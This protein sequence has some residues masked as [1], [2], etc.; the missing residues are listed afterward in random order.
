M[1]D[2]SPRRTTGEY[3]DVARRLGT[4]ASALL[5]AAVV[6]VTG[7][8]W[9]RVDSLESAVKRVS[10]PRGS[11]PDGATDILVVGTDSRVDVH[12]DAMSEAELAR[13]H[14]GVDDGGVNTD[15]IILIRIPNDGHSAT[16]MSIPR[17][18]YVEVPRIGKA[19]INAAFGTAMAGARARLQDQG[20]PQQR[21]DDEAA[22]AGRAA[23]VE[24]VANLTGVTVDHYAEVGLMGF[25]LLTSAVGGVDV[26]LAHAV[27]DDYSGARFP[28]GRQVLDGPRALS[29]VRQRHG[30]PR[31]DL[32]RIVRQQVFMASFAHKVLSAG[33]LADPGTLDRLQRAIHRSVTIDDRWDTV[34]FARQLAD[35]SAGSVRFATIPVVRDDG[36]SDDGQ[37]SVVIV[38]PAQVQAYT[39]ALLGRRPGDTAGAATSAAS[40]PPTGEVAVDVRNS[41]RTEGLASA[42]SEYLAAK[43]FAR[44]T[45]GNSYDDAHAVGS[46]VVAPSAS[47]PGAAAVATQLGGLPISTDRAVRAG[48]VIVILDD[49]YTGP[50][51]PSFS[52][53][54]R[55]AFSAA[56]NGGVP[57]VD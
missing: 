34:G 18:S 41:G 49:G 4:A 39:R 38:D 30:L 5:A 21:V 24:A 32:D 17:D 31:G 36:W 16:A 26:C 57:C 22:E 8:A 51:S 3:R 29:F 7:Y 37:Q 45:V 9:I 20:T 23:L 56:K 35:L 6:A 44:G 12:G 50:G 33:T 47:D 15:T 55:P 53:L 11:A 42:V 27:A 10:I 1:P 48:H 46:T 54:N 28:T 14:A 43:G 2:S 52:I 13:L 19:K 25:S 40:R